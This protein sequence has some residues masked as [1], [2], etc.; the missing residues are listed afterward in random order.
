MERQVA[1]IR[2]RRLR[3]LHFSS[4]DEKNFYSLELVENASSSNFDCVVRI[5]LPPMLQT[6]SHRNFRKTAADSARKSGV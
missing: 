2:G 1:R 4:R 6:H 5:G 3:E